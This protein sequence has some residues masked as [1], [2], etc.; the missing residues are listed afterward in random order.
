[1]S[2]ILYNVGSNGPIG[3]ALTTIYLLRNTNQ[4]LLYYVSGMIVN[5]VINFILKNIIRQPRPSDDANSFRLLTKRHSG[6]L[7]NIKTLDIFGMPSGHSQTALFS[8][9]FV[10][11]TFEN[12]FIT[13]FYLFVTSI[14]LWQRVHYGFHTTMQVFVGGIVGS[15]LATA[16]FLSARKK[17]GGAMK[18][19]DD[20]DAP[21]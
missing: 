21:L 16:V 6:L 3:L 8:T 7:D 19:K 18:L 5:V 10:H 9:V 1:M 14:V 20:D 12:S 4:L 13:C 2:T 17:L 15:I 11:L